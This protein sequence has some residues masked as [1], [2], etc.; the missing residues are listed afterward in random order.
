MI[1]DALKKLSF[2]EDLS[3]SEAEEAM[4]QIMRGEAT[5]AQIAGFVMALRGKGEK[6]VEVA[7][8]VRSMRKHSEMV[9][10]NDSRAVDGCGTGGDGGHT[11]NV[12]TTASLMAAG[13]G[14]TVAK[15]G[16]RSV[17][18]RCGSA[19][20]LESL[21]GNVDPG[22]TRVERH[23]NEIGFGFM[24]AP[25]FH[26]AM[27]HAAPVRKELGVRTVFNILGPLTN[28]AS[29]R[30]QVIGV[31][32]KRVM[33]LVADVL[34]L[35]GCDHAIV[36]HSQDGLDEFSISAPSD[37]IEVHDGAIT[38]GTVHADQMGLT[39]SSLD[40]IAG[41]DSSVNA[42]IVRS[43]LEGSIGAPL[44]ASLLNAGAM[45]Y[46]A[47][48]AESIREGVT[49][50]RQAVKEGKAVALLDKWISA[51]REAVA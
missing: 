14:V 27:R 42:R 41:G 15:H 3:M 4:D 19:D 29:V 10:V 49:V 11:F 46:V 32:D 8:C 22:R 38:N 13:A 30:R 39:V 47:E 50:A 44:D 28:P 31:Y 45:L 12:S 17:S 2:R 37:F 35:N 18:S 9:H 25:R 24:F 16:N 34:A 36:V 7:G 21:G 51:G 6:A 48:R 20:V 23:I 26:P 43:V 5:S 40:S 1:A 33:R